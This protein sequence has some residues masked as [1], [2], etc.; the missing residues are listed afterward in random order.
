MVAEV[1][2]PDET[3]GYLVAMVRRRLNLLYSDALRPLGV[4]T[5][6]F[7]VLSRLWREDGQTVDALVLALYTDQSSLSR[8]LE[9]MV[10]AKLVVRRRDPDDKRVRRISLTP[11]G[12]SLER[13]VLRVRGQVERRLTRGFSQGEF[14]RMQGDLRKLL[15]NLAS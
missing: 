11:R 3:I 2:Q 5:R 10:K 1:S 9:R 14:A 6:Q 4:T 13:P 7:G 8:V 12:R 15:E